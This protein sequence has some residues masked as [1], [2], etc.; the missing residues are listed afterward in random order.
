MRLISSATVAAGLGVGF[1]GQSAPAGMAQGLPYTGTELPAL[2]TACRWQS[3]T[4]PARYTGGT[5][6]MRG[7]RQILWGRINSTMKVKKAMPQHS[8]AIGVS[9]HGYAKVR[10]S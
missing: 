6:W 8:T 4:R 7:D 2:M 9:I 1:I 3:H 10:L 5:S